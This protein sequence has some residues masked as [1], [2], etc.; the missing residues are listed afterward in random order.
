MT[1]I[2]VVVSLTIL[3][4]I[5]VFVATVFVSSVSI[6]NKSAI[7]K[8]NNENAAAGIENKMAGFDPDGTI[9]VASQSSGSL[10]IVF[11]GVTI[12]AN[13][14]FVRSRSVSGDTAFSYFIPN[15]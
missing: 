1:L 4:M 8:R 14:T 6:I 10:Q 12:T 2:E 5:F 11:N 3:S 13:G 9:S 7:A 15:S